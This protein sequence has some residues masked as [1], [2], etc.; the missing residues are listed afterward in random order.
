MNTSILLSF[1]TP[2]GWRKA[3]TDTLNTWEDESRIVLEY[4]TEGRIS[5]MMYLV[6]R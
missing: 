6:N 3:G 1:K 2:N 4:D 5:E